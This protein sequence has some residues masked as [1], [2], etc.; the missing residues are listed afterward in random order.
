[1]PRTEARRLGQQ[2]LD[3]AEG[4]LGMIVRRSASDVGFFHRTF[5]EYLAA[6]HLTRLPMSKQQ[7]LLAVH[8][9]HSQWTETSS[10]LCLF[11]MTKRTDQ[12]EF[13]VQVI[14]N[15]KSTAR[16]LLAGTTLRHCSLKLHLG[17]FAALHDWQRGL[18]QIR[19]T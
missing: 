8:C 3:L 10:S 9:V 18:R 11:H 16:V 13:L 19:L 5:H 7:D 14:E 12:V 17:T 2:L 6:C 4:N 1:M 15:A